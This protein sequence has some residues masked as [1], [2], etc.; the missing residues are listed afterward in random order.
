MSANQ[1]IAIVGAASLRGKELNEALGESPFASAD[2][3]QMDF[4]FF[5]GNAELTRKHWETAVH[6]GS[7]VIDLSGALD[8]E[9]GAVVLAPWVQDSV[10]P[11]NLQTPAVVP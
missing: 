6:A 9:K 5:A 11:L 1:R 10:K 2:F 7:A 8:T 3:V 4:T